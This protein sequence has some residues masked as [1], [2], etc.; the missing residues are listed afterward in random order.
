MTTTVERWI[1]ESRTKL[2]AAPLEES[3]LDQLEALI[4]EPRQLI[5]Y[6]TATSTNLRSSVVSWVIFDSA[7]KQEP[8]LPDDRPPYASVLDAVSNGWRVTQFPVINLYDYKDLENDYVGFD[9][10][11]EKMV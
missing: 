4:A 6:L 8:E 9:F 2:K 5:M 10:I 11:L 1:T 7:R 3:D